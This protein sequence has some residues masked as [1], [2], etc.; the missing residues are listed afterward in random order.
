MSWINDSVPFLKILT[1]DTDSSPN[2]CSPKLLSLLVVAASL[3]KQEIYFPT[4]YTISIT[5]KTITPEPDETFINFMVLK[6]ACITDLTTYRTRAALEGLKAQV[7]PANLTVG[8]YA[9]AFKV[10]LDE[11][12]CKMYEELKQQYMF[13]QNLVYTVQAILSPF[14]NDRFRPQEMLGG[15]LADSPRERETYNPDMI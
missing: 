8:G 13:S 15:G 6:A 4:T 2:Y 9:G 12:P 7:G 11:G 10:L 1:G 14:I 3:V 5:G